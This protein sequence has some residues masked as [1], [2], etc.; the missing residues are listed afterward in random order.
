M[1]S[2]W[3]SSC[4]SSRTRSSITKS[5]ASSAPTRS[6]SA[7]SAARTRTP[8]VKRGCVTSARNSTPACAATA[9]SA[10]AT[11]RS[12]GGSAGKTP[13]RTHPAR[14]ATAIAGRAHCALLPA[15]LEEL[16]QLFGLVRDQ[17]QPPVLGLQ[18]TFFL[19]V[20]EIR[21]QVIEVAGDVQKPARLGM[22]AELRPRHDLD[23]LLERAE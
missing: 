23:D 1:R 7:S 6:A 10:W 13:L 18:E 4:A 22:K 5:S 11:R 16:E 2:T 20:R 21:D 14:S 15:A 19:R 8:T 3:S 12:P 17:Q 9:A